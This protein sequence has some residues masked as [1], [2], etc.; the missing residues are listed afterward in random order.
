MRD[1]CR[2]HGVDYDREASVMIY[3][4]EPNERWVLRMDDVWERCE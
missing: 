1:L 2:R 4:R 3:F